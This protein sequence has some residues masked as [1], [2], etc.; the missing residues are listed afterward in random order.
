[1]IKSFI[2]NIEEMNSYVRKK[3]SSRKQKLFNSNSFNN[4]LATQKVKSSIVEKNTFEH[5]LLLK[6]G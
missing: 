2:F 6:E 3:S 1:M 4:E 5:L